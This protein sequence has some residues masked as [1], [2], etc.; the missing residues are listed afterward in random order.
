[1]NCV[2]IGTGSVQLEENLNEY[3]YVRF[4]LILIKSL[5]NICLLES[6]SNKKLLTYK[7][8]SESKAYIS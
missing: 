4:F 1:M 7:Q 2:Q 8:S 5:D 3:G 6:F